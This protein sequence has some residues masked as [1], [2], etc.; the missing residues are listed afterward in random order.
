MLSVK[1]TVLFSW[2]PICMP[3]I[4]LLALMKLASTSAAIMYNSMEDRHPWQTP[5]VKLKGSDRKP[6]FF[7]IRLDIGVYIFDYA[8]E[9]IFISEIMQSRKVKIPIS[10]K[11]ITEKILFSLFVTSIM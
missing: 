8:N 7:Q 6:F 11:D 5:L 3:L 1:L 10:S 4:L 9:F 2:P